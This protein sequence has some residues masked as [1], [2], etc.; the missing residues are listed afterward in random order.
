MHNFDYDGSSASDD[1]PWSSSRPD[2]SSSVGIPSQIPNQSYHSEVKF[3]DDQGFT[4]IVAHD[5]GNLLAFS[6][7]ATVMS[8]YY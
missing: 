8:I 3:S 6:Y 2:T 5:E 7:T 4:N 1:Q